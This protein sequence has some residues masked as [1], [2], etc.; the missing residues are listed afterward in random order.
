MISTQP[1]ILIIFFPAI[2]RIPLPQGYL[3]SCL[4]FHPLTT[5]SLFNSEQLTPEEI[6]AI[7]VSDLQ[8]L[9]ALKLKAAVLNAQTSLYKS[10]GIHKHTLKPKQTVNTDTGRPEWTQCPASEFKSVHQINL[11]G[12]VISVTFVSMGVS[13]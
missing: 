6:A 1:Y 5:P 9:R 7:D 10:T 8:K 4:C 2:S 12:E 11:P 3:N 13:N